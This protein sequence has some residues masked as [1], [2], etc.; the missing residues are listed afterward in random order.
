MKRTRD[1]GIAAKRGAALAAAFIVALACGLSGCS[2]QKAVRQLQEFEWIV[3]SDSPEATQQ[4]R[5]LEAKQAELL[6]ADAVWFLRLQ[7]GEE[8]LF[9]V[10]AAMEIDASERV[11]GDGDSIGGEKTAQVCIYD[12]R[13]GLPKKKSQPFQQ[14]EIKDVQVD[15]LT[16]VSLSDV[17]FDGYT[18]LLVGRQRSSANV[19]FSVFLWDAQEM[20]FVECDALSQLCSPK[21]D[22][23]TEI[24]TAKYH[25][26]DTTGSVEFYRWTEGEL[27]AVRRIS[28]GAPNERSLSGQVYDWDEDHWELLYDRQVVLDDS[29]ASQ[30]RIDQLMQELYEYYDLNVI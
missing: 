13:E 27:L 25:E 12:L 20:C 18:D 4:Q 16:I 30:L 1:W 8:Q 6:S 28:Y 7:E 9:E 2:G 22:A 21:A 14:F 26:N 10:S 19:W 17:N 3:N 29:E 24:I 5:E 15:A 11:G 23:E